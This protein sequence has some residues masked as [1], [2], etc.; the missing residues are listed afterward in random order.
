MSDE[1]TTLFEEQDTKQPKPVTNKEKTRKRPSKASKAP[2]IKKQEEKEQIE[3]RERAFKTMKSISITQELMPFD[4]VETDKAIEYAKSHFNR[5]FEIFYNLDE[6]IQSFIK[7]GLL[8]EQSFKSYIMFP[9]MFNSLL[10]NGMINNYAF[11]MF[12]L[13]DL[14]HDYYL[15]YSSTIKQRVVLPKEQ[16]VPKFRILIKI[17]N[18]LQIVN[19]IVSEEIA[20]RI[21][22]GIYKAKSL[23]KHLTVEID[24]KRFKYTLFGG[25]LCLREKN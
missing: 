4:I 11:D 1:D 16:Y 24:K 9:R 5:Q 10:V 19:S 15:L 6:K 13:I 14:L 2:K 18:D 7:T 23:N 20:Q 21:E 22:A 3:E 25:A 12:C 17:Q 8:T